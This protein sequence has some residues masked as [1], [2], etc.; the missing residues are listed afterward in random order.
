MGAPKHPESKAK[1]ERQHQLI[2]HVRCICESN[3]EKFSVALYRVALIRNASQSET[4]NLE[5][6]CAAHTA[7]ARVTYTGDQKE[8]LNIG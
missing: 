1:V 3:A 7:F 6:S 4:T 5:C 8:E 2:A